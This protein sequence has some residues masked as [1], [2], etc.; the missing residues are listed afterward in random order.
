MAQ[1]PGFS[2]GRDLKKILTVQTPTRMAWS[3]SCPFG[4]GGY[5]LQGRAWRLQVPY[6]CP[7]YGEDTANN[8][9]EFLGMAV[10][11]MLLLKEAADNQDCILVLGD[12]T[13]AVSWIFRS[14]RVSRNSRYYRAVKL[15]ARTIAS[16][17]L[18]AG[19]Q[20][21]SQHLAGVTNTVQ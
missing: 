17:A 12:N 11:I 21:C 8:V 4:L 15:I 2:K 16:H 18:Q 20:I 3:D 9:L 14:G 1:V 10:S 19:A 13:A 7:F 5:S 6:N